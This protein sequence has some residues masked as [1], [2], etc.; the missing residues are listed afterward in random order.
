M[1]VK[2]TQEAKHGTDKSLDL[3]VKAVLEKKAADIT[4]L[5]V[6]GLTSVADF[7][8]VCSGRS[9]RQ[10]AAIADSVERYLKKKGIK[11]LSVEGKNE[12]LWVLLDYGDVII[13]VFYETVR[14]FYDL[15]GLWSDA[16]RIV[17]DGMM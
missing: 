5:D 3:Y 7:F 2:K 12:G 14:K 8:I 13:H 1:T 17:T 16:K 15:E 9:N 11:P 10:V 4:V 6:R